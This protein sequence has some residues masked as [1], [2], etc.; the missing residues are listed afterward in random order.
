MWQRALAVLVTIASAT[1]C[2]VTS[3]RGATGDDGDPEPASAAAAEPGEAERGA[4]A[5]PA[6]AVG[7][8]ALPDGMEPSS[9]GPAM[10][11]VFAPDGVAVRSARAALDID[12]TGAV[13]VR[14]DVELANTGAATAEARV[15]YAFRLQGGEADTRALGGVR[16]DGGYAV[17]RCAEASPPQMHAVFRD[18]ALWAVVPVPAGG[19]ATVQGEAA[20]ALQRASAATTLLGYADPAAHNLRNFKWSYVKDAAY[21]A[22]ADRA[23]PFHDRVVLLPAESL[24]VAIATGGE[25]WLRAVSFE[26]AVV[27]VQ[28]IGALQLRFG[29]GEAPAAIDIELNP[30]LDLGEELA[31][32]RKLSAARPDDLRAAI[33][34]AD[35]LRFGGDAKERAAALERALAAWDGNAKAQLLTG[36]SD[37][38]APLYV[39]LVRSLEAAGKK[40]DARKRAAE[41]LEVAKTLDATT[42]MN[43]LAVPWLERYVAAKAE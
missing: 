32:F 2:A 1:G 5:A 22:I 41:G 33:R 31:V 25:P 39:A 6:G 7:R 23:K 15:G 40:A 43:R 21:A 14:F 34:V 3:S 26:Q 9:F 36:R 30:D 24:Q 27:P 8:C 12:S 20:F 4:A 35:L 11:R 16:F 42:D 37:V 13:R 10:P 38:R 17:E 28:A 19:A 29:P 18:E